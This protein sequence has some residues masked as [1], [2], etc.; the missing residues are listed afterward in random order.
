MS[1]ST[2]AGLSFRRL[3]AASW[4]CREYLKTFLSFFSGFSS[5]LFD[6]AQFFYEL[7]TSMLGLL[8]S[9]LGPSSVKL[10]RVRA[11][12]YGARTIAQRPC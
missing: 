2:L 7:G 10:V 11:S 1:G 8:G 5:D 4:V 3:P 9:F 12:A 6:F